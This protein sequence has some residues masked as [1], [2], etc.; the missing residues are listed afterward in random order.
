ML[1]A[2]PPFDIYRSRFLYSLS[3]IFSFVLAPFHAAVDC[4]FWSALGLAL[5]E[6]SGQSAL[7]DPLLA[8]ILTH[9]PD[10]T[11]TS[12]S[13]S[14]ASVLVFIHSHSLPL[15]EILLANTRWS[16]VPACVFCSMLP[17]VFLVE[18]IVPIDLA[19][20]ENS[21][22]FSYSFFSFSLF[23]MSCLHK[24]KG[25]VKKKRLISSII[26]LQ[27]CWSWGLIKNLFWVWFF[28]FSLGKCFTRNSRLWFDFGESFGDVKF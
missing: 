21:V 10:L 5:S 8:R 6:S 22:T 19:Y 24:K 28:P 18:V 2:F 16:S 26:R 15:L 23:P 12:C 25:T 14:S 13:L 17:C 11:R 7:N 4:F 27:S 20:S 1:F 3:S 9:S